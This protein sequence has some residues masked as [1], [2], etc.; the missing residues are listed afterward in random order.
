MSWKIFFFNQRNCIYEVMFSFS[1]INQGSIAGSEIKTYASGSSINIKFDFSGGWCLLTCGPLVWID[2]STD[3]FFNENN[4]KSPFHA[5]HLTFP[6]H[7]CPPPRPQLQTWWIDP[8]CREIEETENV[9]LRRR[10][11]RNCLIVP[12][13]R[14]QLILQSCWVCSG[15]VCADRKL[16][17]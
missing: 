10:L 7:P 2:N 11:W 14:R 13:K 15:I 6:T 3:I 16:R 5:L 1:I 12:L 17:T 4:V 9:E 8:W